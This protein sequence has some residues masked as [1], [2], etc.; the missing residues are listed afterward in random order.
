MRTDDLIA[1]DRREVFDIRRKRDKK[2]LGRK[3]SMSVVYEK[4]GFVLE[5]MVC[6]FTLFAALWIIL[7][8]CGIIMPLGK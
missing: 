6:F 2:L 7:N 8:E 1:R 5:A 4:I 3:E